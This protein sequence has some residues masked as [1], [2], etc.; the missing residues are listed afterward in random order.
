MAAKVDGEHRIAEP[1]QPDRMSRQTGART[2]DAVEKQDRRR[3]RPHARPIA[4]RDRHAIASD[5]MDDA[6]GRQRWRHGA[7]HRPRHDRAQG[8][9][10]READQA[11]DKQGKE[12]SAPCHSGEL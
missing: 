5:E 9:D 12:E 3:F 11:N 8:P 4:A 7:R 10:A 1:V 2:V 6:P